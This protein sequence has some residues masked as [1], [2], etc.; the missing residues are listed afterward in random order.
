[1]KQV[2]LFVYNHHGQLVGPLS[3]PRIEK[4]DAEWQDV[5]EWEDE[6]WPMPATEFYPAP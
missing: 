6:S 1:M 4:S 5:L 2:P 3:I